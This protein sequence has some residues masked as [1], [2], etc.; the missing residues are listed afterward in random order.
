MGV[1]MLR[2]RDQIRDKGEERSVSPELYS[3]DFVYF[4][5]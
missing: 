3:L 4:D 2:L 5:L 1:S